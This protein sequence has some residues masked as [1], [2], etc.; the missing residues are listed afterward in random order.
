MRNGAGRTLSLIRDGAE[1]A[2]QLVAADD[3]SFRRLAA[4]DYRVAMAG[5]QAISGR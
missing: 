3:L 2:T 4:G 1:V 5:S